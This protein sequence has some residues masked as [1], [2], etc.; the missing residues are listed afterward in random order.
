LS[1]SGGFSERNDP[2]TDRRDNHKNALQIGL[3]Q[4]G[5]T[6]MRISKF[7]LIAGVLPWVTAFAETDIAVPNAGFEEGKKGWTD[8]KGT[9]QVLKEA[10]Q[11]G[12]GGLRIVD[13]SEQ[14]YVRVVSDPISIT[15]G[16][17]YRLECSFN[18]VAGHG[19]NAI[20]WFL[21]KDQEIIPWPDG[22]RLLIRPS[23]TSKGWEKLSVEGKAPANAAYAQIH[24]QS[25][26]IATDTTVDWDDVT[27]KQLD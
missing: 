11:T 10:A 8:D 23:D 17:T 22:S 19:V 9:S 20:L 4:A 26:R 7:A 14:D 5:L 1:C 6:F 12:E 3:Q 27:L 24:I 18:Q 25:N 15:P 2:A 13:N 21:D 16:K